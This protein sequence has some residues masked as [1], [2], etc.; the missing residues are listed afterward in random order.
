[1]R[2]IGEY[3]DDQVSAAQIAAGNSDTIDSNT[4]FDVRYDVQLDELFNLGGEGT[5]LSVGAVNLFDESQPRLVNR[6]NIDFEVH[7]P[8]S[9]QVYVSFKQSF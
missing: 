8:R 7:D 4:T 5:S 2:H 6:P 3:T 1:M 9:R